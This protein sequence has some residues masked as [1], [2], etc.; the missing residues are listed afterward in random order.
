MTRPSLKSP[1][2]N[3]KEREE[4]DIV[5]AMSKLSDGEKIEQGMMYGRVIIEMLGRPKEHLEKTFRDFIGALHHD[6]KLDIKK[7]DIAESQE[8]E[9]GMYSI[10][11]EVELWFAD[12]PKVGAF[13]LDY[14]PSSI[15]LIEPEEL[16]FDAHE[17]SNYFNDFQAKL[18]SLD[19]LAK[20]L[21]AQ[22]KKLMD[23][24]LT[25]I[26]NVVLVSVQQ[27]PKTLEDLAKNVGLDAA[28]LKPFIEKLVKDKI[29][30]KEN[31]MYSLGVAGL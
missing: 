31:E 13:C 26:R 10:F 16:V 3:A 30:Q 17:L 8:V 23:N 18:H 27:K 25:L 20:N 4:P 28:Q 19:M 7:V 1:D 21:Q 24:S 9:D 22:N 5:T 15:E 14:M 11:A 6:Q 29:L 12:V 2:K